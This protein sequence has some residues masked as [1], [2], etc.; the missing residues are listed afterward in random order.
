MFRG[1]SCL[2]MYRAKCR[3]WHTSEVFCAAGLLMPTRE[4]NELVKDNTGGNLIAWAATDG[5]NVV[6]K[7]QPLDPRFKKMFSDAATLSG[8]KRDDLVANP[9]HTQRI[10]VRQGLPIFLSAHHASARFS[11]YVPPHLSHE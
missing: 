2:R 8:K 1:R 5:L 9:G 11:Q 3:L 10:G 4:I 6:S 7:V